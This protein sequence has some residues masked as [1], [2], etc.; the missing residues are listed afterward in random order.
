MKKYDFT[1]DLETDNSNSIILRWIKP[2]STVLEFGPAHGRMTKFLKE[3]LRCSVTIIELDAESG[4]E[5]AR[6]AERALIGEIEGNIESDLWV[7]KLQGGTFDYIIF[8]DVLEHLHNP[9]KTLAAAIGL[10][11]DGG[12]IIVSVPNLAHNSVLIELWNNRFEY[13]NTGL[14]DETHLCFFSKTSLAKLVHQAG[15]RVY[16]EHN[17]SCAVDNTEFKHSLAD[18][19]REVAKAMAKREHADIYQFVWELKKAGW[20][21]THESLLLNRP[22]AMS[23][24]PRPKISVLLPNHNYGRYL[25][26][27]IESIL[28]QD[29]TDFEFIIS[30]D[31]SSDN[32]AD[33]IRSYAARDA[34]IKSFIQPR[35]L[36]MVGNW[37]WCLRQARGKYIKYLFGDD[38]LSSPHALSTLAGMLEANPG[39]ALATSARELIDDQGKFITLWDHLGRP[40]LKKADRVA[41]LCLFQIENYIG[42]PTA[43]MFRSSATDRGFDSSY[44]QV[45]DLEMWLHLLKQGDL[46][47]TS[48]PLCQFRQHAEQQTAANRK[49]KISYHE[50]RHLNEDYLPG[51]MPKDKSLP[52]REKWILFKV[53]HMLEKSSEISAAAKQHVPFLKLQLGPRWYKFLRIC[54]WVFSKLCRKFCRLFSNARRFWFKHVLRDPSYWKPKSQA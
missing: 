25:E 52:F 24:S 28:R 43:V 41:R 1:L 7:Q 4:T 36:G 37:N 12:S 8:C 26:L 35:N 32:S 34:R 22:H 47:Y 18:V 38:C 30:D 15:F 17:T 49:T 50:H 19:P 27:A 9:G 33:I 48:E 39:A 31:A 2:Q 40:G 23:D 21:Q 3:N 16:N 10:L 46:V 42:E 44:R 45:V 6:Y 53:I 20:R 51:F 13:R 54:H 5:A 14:L 11:S 29:F